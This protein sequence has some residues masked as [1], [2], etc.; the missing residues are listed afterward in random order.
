MYNI[1]IYKDKKGCFFLYINMA[2]YVVE[3]FVIFII[4]TCQ[5]KHIIKNSE[6]LKLSGQ[7]LKAVKNSRLFA[8]FSQQL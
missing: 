8:S 2:F 6:K 5:K 4:H 1:I 7:L 3:F